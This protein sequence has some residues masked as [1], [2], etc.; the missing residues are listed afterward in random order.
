[1]FARATAA[2]VALTLSVPAQATDQQRV[3]QTIKVCQEF[4]GPGRMGADAEAMARLS[5]E[6]MADLADGAFARA[7]D[8]YHVPLEQRKV[9]RLMC[10]FYMQG[11]QDMAA[12]AVSL[13]TP[14]R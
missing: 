8:K 11:G 12:Y 2:L 5:P 9:V 14:S 10:S 13:R 4:M 7:A 6:R 1:M 3:D